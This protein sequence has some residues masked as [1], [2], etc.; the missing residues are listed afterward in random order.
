MPRDS[1]NKKRSKYRDV[2]YIEVRLTASDFLKE[3]SRRQTNR[4]S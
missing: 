3:F 4:L 2:R 1:K